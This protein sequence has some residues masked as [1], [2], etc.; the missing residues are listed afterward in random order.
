MVLSAALFTSSAAE[1]FFR[2]DVAYLAEEPLYSYPTPKA[3]EAS[4]LA[5]GVL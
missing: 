4:L 2:N 1:I 3:A 5:M